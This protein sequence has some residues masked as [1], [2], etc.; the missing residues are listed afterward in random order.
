MTTVMKTKAI[1]LLTVTLTTIIVLM[2]A[3]FLFPGIR[4]D[5]RT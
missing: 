1:T 4:N 3:D 5:K 2:I